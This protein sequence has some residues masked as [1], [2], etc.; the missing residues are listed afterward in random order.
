MKIAY[1]GKN[2][3]VYITD[4]EYQKWGGGLIYNIISLL[5]Q[6]LSPLTQCWLGL[7]C[8]SLH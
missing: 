8:T 2:A 6:L 3:A 7:A 5:T 4:S 1:L